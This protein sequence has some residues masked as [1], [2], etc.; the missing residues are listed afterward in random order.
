MDVPHVSNLAVFIA[1]MA[2]LLVYK[3]KHPIKRIIAFVIVWFG[4]GMTI[5]F[6]YVV[7]SYISTGQLPPQ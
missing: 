4:I 3:V 6:I 7:I 1:V 2:A 5:A